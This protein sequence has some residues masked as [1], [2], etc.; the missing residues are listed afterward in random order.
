VLETRFSPLNRYP[1]ERQGRRKMKYNRRRKEKTRLNFYFEGGGKI[2]TLLEGFQ[3]S[4]ARPSD[5]NSM[6]IK[7]LELCKLVA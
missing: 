6:K 3:V 7:M 4:P 1:G 2:I 5:K